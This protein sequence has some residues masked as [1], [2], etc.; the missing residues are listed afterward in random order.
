MAEF[1]LQDQR[2]Q[3]LL[4]IQRSPGQRKR[5]FSR[6]TVTAE[7]IPARW[8]GKAA[9]AAQ[10]GNNGNEPATTGLAEQRKPIPVELQVAGKATGWEEQVL[11]AFKKRHCLLED[12]LKAIRLQSI[13]PRISSKGYRQESCPEMHWTTLHS[14]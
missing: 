3:W 7:M 2:N 10:G 12:R 8:K 14:L 4:I 13:I 11:Y 6:Q 5:L 9:A 1:P